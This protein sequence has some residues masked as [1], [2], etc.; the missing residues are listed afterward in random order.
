MEQLLGHL[1][2]DWI[3]KIAHENASEFY[4]HQLPADCKP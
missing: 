2:D 3:R 4:R 1:P